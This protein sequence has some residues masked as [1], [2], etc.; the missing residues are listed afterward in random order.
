MCCSRKCPHEN[1]NGDCRRPY[2]GNT[3]PC[4]DDAPEDEEQEAIE[5]VK[6]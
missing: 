2:P 6:R 5:E 4:P 3:Q 1:R